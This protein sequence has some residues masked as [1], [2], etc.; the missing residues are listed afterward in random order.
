MK[1]KRPKPQGKVKSHDELMKSI[2]ARMDKWERME[3]GDI[4]ALIE[5]SVERGLATKEDFPDHFQA[6]NARA[7]PPA[8]EG[9]VF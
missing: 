7:R 3:N 8:Y 6:S 1:S 2:K 5:L 9:E 4:K